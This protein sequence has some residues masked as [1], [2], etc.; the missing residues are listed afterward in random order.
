MENKDLEKIREE[1]G[2][3]IASQASIALILHAKYDALIQAGFSKK[4]ALYI[5]T[6]QGITIGGINEQRKSE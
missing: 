5:V 6:T 3:I 4:D 1:L 2:T